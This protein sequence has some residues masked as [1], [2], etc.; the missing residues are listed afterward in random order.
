MSTTDDSY[1]I[2]EEK[3]A[4]HKTAREKWWHVLDTYKIGIIP[5]PFFILAGV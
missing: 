2:A 3:K 4:G 5:L 1:L